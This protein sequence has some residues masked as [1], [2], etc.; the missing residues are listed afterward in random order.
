L[1]RGHDAVAP[2]KITVW[3]ARIRTVDVLL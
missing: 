2:Q 3:V 1:V